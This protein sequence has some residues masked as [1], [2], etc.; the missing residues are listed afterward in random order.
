MIG[1]FVMFGILEVILILLF[2]VVC[3]SC[4]LGRFGNTRLLAVLPLDFHGRLRVVRTMLI[5]GAFTVL[6]HLFFL[7]RSLLT[8]RSALVSAGWSKRQAPDS[9]LVSEFA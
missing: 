1:S 5:P 2:G 8:L 3:Y 4:S 6:R 7:R 9:M